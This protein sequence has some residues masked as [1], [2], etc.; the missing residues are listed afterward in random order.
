MQVEASAQNIASDIA[1]AEDFY[2]QARFN[3]ALSLLSSIEERLRA[4][5]SASD[6]ARVKMLSGLCHLALDDQPQ[7]RARFLEFCVLEPGHVFDEQRFPPKVVSIFKEVSEDCDR[8]V[9]QCSRGAEPAAAGNSGNAAVRDAHDERCPCMSTVAVPDDAHLQRG[10]D[11]L[12][13]KKYSEALQEFQGLLRAAPE[14]DQIR[15]GV[16]L[17]QKEIDSALNAAVSD[18]RRLFSER[19]FEQ[20]AVVY[21]VIRSLENDSTGQPRELAAQISVQYQTTFRDLFTT[22]NSACAR[23]DSVASVAIRQWGRDLDPHRVI[24]PE[25]LDRM[26]ECNA[27]SGRN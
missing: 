27:V 17:A 1:R 23:K 14:N 7:A 19:Q 16:E 25:M 9:R 15:Q 11:L 21:E 12:L 22:W 18:W 5:G 13:Q 4:D 24:Q 8:C 3:D 26:Q 2:Y 6:K 10:R 20:A